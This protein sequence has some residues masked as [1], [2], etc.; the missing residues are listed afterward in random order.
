[1]LYS[2]VASNVIYAFH[3]I[4]VCS[5][6]VCDTRRLLYTLHSKPFSSPV[7]LYW[8]LPHHLRHPFS[9]RHHACI[10][11]KCS[12]FHIFPSFT[13]IAYFSPSLSFSPFQI[14][15][16]WRLYISVDVK[17]C[18]FCC[19]ICPLPKLGHKDPAKD[20]VDDHDDENYDAE[21]EDGDKSPRDCSLN[22]SSRSLGKKVTFHSSYT[23]LL[24]SF[25]FCCCCSDG[26]YVLRFTVFFV[27]VKMM[28]Y[29]LGSHSQWCG[30]ICPHASPF[31]WYGKSIFPCSHIS[32]SD[33]NA[34]IHIINTLIPQLLSGYSNIGFIIKCWLCCHFYFTPT[35]QIKQKLC[36]ALYCF[37]GQSM[38]VYRWSLWLNNLLFTESHTTNNRI[39]KQSIKWIV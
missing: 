20:A 15:A 7:Y 14:F 39:Q 38:R 6:W 9:L 27:S 3:Y 25:I 37:I 1:M 30:S 12:I 23:Y 33:S 2:K 26:D 29:S 5:C 31:D 16:F 32:C 11:R 21:E 8:A 19:C 4:A 36:L 17:I 10:H 34:V 13:S 35:I 28:L 24:Y 18:C 22:K